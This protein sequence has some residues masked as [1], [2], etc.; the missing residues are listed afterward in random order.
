VKLACKYLRLFLVLSF[1][2]LW[3]AC[4]GINTSY[5]VS[6]ATF[7]L[8]GLMQVEPDEPV[9]PSEI[10]EVPVQIAVNSLR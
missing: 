4:S 8:P 10:D 9:L 3:T 6:P 2:L 7:L 5:G 1:A